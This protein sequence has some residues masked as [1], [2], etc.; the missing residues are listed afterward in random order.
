[1]EIKC[2]AIDDEPLALNLLKKY[3]SSFSELQLLKMFDDAVA[4]DE[5][6]KK[7]KVDLL[8]I[9]INMPDVSGIDLIRS[10]PEKPMLIFTTAYK[11][12]AIEGFDLDAV[13]YLLKPIS[14]ERFT[15]AVLKAIE[16][17]QFKKGIE[18]K[19]QQALF[20]R[21]EYQVVKIE[22]DEIE[23]IESVSDYLKIHRTN[24]KPVMT[25]MTVKSIL[26]KLP[27]EEFKRIHR[28]YIVPVKKIKSIVNKK[29][30]LSNIELPI[31]DNYID[32]V[33]EWKS[34]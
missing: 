3:I 29:A 17:Y 8:F 18:V 11:E 24:E 16:Y 15:R 22:L 12:F 9:D 28:S 10:L 32:I 2:A 14:F 13:D 6:L 4:G 1:M 20:V 26:E 25:L 21:S 31:S 34:K 27:A 19:K 33:R 23:F 7:N 30:K 5:F